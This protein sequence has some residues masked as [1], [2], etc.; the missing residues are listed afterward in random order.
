MKRQYA[1]P[2]QAAALAMILATTSIGAFAPGLVAAVPKRRISTSFQNN[3]QGSPSD[4][5]H[6]KS[7]HE[8]LFGRKNNNCGPSSA[9]LMGGNLFDDIQK[10]FSGGNNGDDE[11]S[12]N[13]SDNDYDFEAENR[14]ATIPGKF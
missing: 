5:R 3:I 13:N 7:R 14:V 12:D 8:F 10:F 9:L 1:W 6:E 4:T 11:N 2:L